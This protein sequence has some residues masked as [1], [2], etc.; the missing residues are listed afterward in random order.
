MKYDVKGLPDLSVQPKGTYRLKVVD[1]KHSEPE[2]NLRVSFKFEILAPENKKGQ[3]YSE[4]YFLGNDDDPQAERPETRRDTSKGSGI[5]W[6]RWKELF[7]RSGIPMVGDTED[8]SQSLVDSGAIVVADIGVRT[9]K[10]RSGE[11]QTVNQ[12]SRYYQDG[13]KEP[14]LADVATDEAPSSAGGQDAAPKV[15]NTTK[16][17]KCGRDVPNARFAAHKKLHDADEGEE[18]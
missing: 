11:M 15:A 3:H 9:Y 1:R 12:I 7:V 10:N 13:K 18:E 5:A 4:S 6:G 2:Q 8:D 16:C 17:D 14:K